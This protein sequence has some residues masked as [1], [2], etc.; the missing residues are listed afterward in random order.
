MYVR[1]QRPLTYLQTYFLLRGL[2]GMVST[3]AVFLRL[4][5]TST[6]MNLP[7][8]ASRPILLQGFLRA[9]RHHLTLFSKD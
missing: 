5:A 4:R 7:V 8:S 6:G 2:Q 1:D 9:I 3:T